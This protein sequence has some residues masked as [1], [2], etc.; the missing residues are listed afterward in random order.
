MSKGNRLVENALV[1]G[2]VGIAGVLMVAV[3][4][5]LAAAPWVILALVLHWIGVF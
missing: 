3:Y 5:A 2:A 4:V 1:G